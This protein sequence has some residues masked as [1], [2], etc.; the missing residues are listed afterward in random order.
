MSKQLTIGFDVTWMNVSGSYGGASQY[1]QRLISALVEHTDLNVVAIT[2][3]EAGKIFDHLVGNK[4]FRIARL[5]TRGLL[6][7]LVDNEGI[8]VIHTPLQYHLNFTTRVPMINTLHDLQHF[9]YPEFFTEEQHKSRD[10]FYKRSSE[11]SER[12]IV[13]FSHVMEDIVRFYD[14]LPKK[15][16][17]CTV[18]VD[19]PR[20]LDASRIPAIRKKY[21][22]PEH[23]LFYSANTWRHKNH[24]GLVKALKILHDKY[25]KKTGLVCTGR[26]FNDFFLE[27]QKEVEKQGLGTYVNFTGYIPEDD[28]LLIMRNASLVVIPTLY[29]AGSYPLYEAIIYGVPVICSNVT[30]L[31][32]TIGDERFLFD[33]RDVN[34]IAEKASLLL[35]DRKL[36]EENIE[37]SRRRVGEMGWEKRVGAFVR[38]YEKAVASFEKK[39]RDE[40]FGA[41]VDNFEFF[42]NNHFVRDQNI[43]QDSLSWRITAPLRW[44]GDMFTMLRHWWSR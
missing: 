38:S 28:L 18:G 7:D 9:H 16:D 41:F 10:T 2:G 31:P 13:S 20:H 44:L 15:I 30:S 12:I 24:I 40:S 36:R 29:E 43:I 25:G 42:V 8:D 11:F 32:D 22:I 14:I 5:A 26:K 37:N 27:I 21:N 6:R 39:R 35:E 23:Y 33:P 17:I 3:P 1:A 34:M 4:N 19:P